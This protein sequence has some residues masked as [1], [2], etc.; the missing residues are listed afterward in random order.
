MSAQSC[1]GC[2]LTYNERGSE[3]QLSAACSF[4]LHEL[5]F[6]TIVLCRIIWLRLYTR[7]R[8]RESVLRS[9]QPART[10][11]QHGHDCIS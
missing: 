9:S 1:N 4:T 10:L 5:C 11:V 2:T 6:Y 3:S 7:E 8:E